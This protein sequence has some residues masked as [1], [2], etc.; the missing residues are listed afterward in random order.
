MTT[1]VL[2][3]A[4]IP[5]LIL[6]KSDGGSVLLRPAAPGTG[7]IAGG[8]V[9]AVLEAAGIKDVLT[10]SLRSNNPIAVVYATLNGLLNLRSLKLIKAIRFGNNHS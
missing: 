9:R 7:V 8:G 10:K 1:I 5:H 6:G 4:T 2:R 3:G